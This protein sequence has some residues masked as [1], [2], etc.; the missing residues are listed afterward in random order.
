MKY[1]KG[2]RVFYDTS[3]GG[4]DFESGVIQA[5]FEDK[6]VI[7]SGYRTFV[8]TEHQLDKTMKEAYTILNESLNEQEDERNSF[9]NPPTRFQLWLDKLS[10]L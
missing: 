3:Y 7:D 5:Y 2:K 8:V 4:K 10:M 1:K 9:G 6:Y